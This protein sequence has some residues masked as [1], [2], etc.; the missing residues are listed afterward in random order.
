[1]SGYTKLASAATSVQESAQAKSYEHKRLSYRTVLSDEG[2]KDVVIEVT[3]NPDKEKDGHQPDVK[4]AVYSR[5]YFEKTAKK[6]ALKVYTPEM[7]LRWAD[8]H[9]IGAPYK[10]EDGP[11]QRR[12]TKIRVQ[13]KFEV[14]YDKVLNE[15]VMNLNA[16][17][18]PYDDINVE[19]AWFVTQL[20]KL[21]RMICRAIWDHKDAF[22]GT[23][24]KPGIRPTL[25]NQARS[26]ISAK[27]G[28]QV[29][30]V[31]STNPEVIERAFELFLR[32]DHRSKVI[33]V[34]TR[35]SE[36]DVCPAGIDCM[37]EEC[38]HPEH[39][40]G[41]REYV[42]E[43]RRRVF[44]LINYEQNKDREIPSVMSKAI[45]AQWDAM[46]PG[47]AT[48]I[49]EVEMKR[50]RDELACKE[51]R[52]HGLLFAPIFYRTGKTLNVDRETALNTLGPAQGLYKEMHQQFL[53]YGHIIRQCLR[54]SGQAFAIKGGA[55]TS[56]NFD[57]MEIVVVA[58]A[59]VTYERDNADDLYTCEDIDM[60]PAAPMGSSSSSSAFSFG[61]IDTM[62]ASADE[63]VAN[64]KRKASPDSL[65]GTNKQVRFEN[66]YAH[67]DDPYAHE[68]DHHE[69]TGGY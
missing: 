36:P 48:R 38:T 40:A 23:L 28:K 11:I 22:M 16:H 41:K 8:I 34:D 29:H 37:K 31:P 44:E 26:D 30:E 35:M 67:E 63:P 32:H 68:E 1:M 65:V 51:L 10:G 18:R 7:P 25:V 61:E 54:I 42:V 19:V 43:S 15:K 13:T 9:S 4:V 3:S 39:K 6:L 59:P 20:Q 53:R 52:K 66:P 55:G 21:D 50:Q 45:D 14:E 58:K 64:G 2:L 57:P 24:D 46:N 5:A 33:A 56:I 49:H 60:L 12:K 17:V 27:T 62:P 69:D 47:A